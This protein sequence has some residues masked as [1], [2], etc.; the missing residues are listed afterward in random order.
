[1]IIGIKSGIYVSNYIRDI[2]KEIKKIDI[3]EHKEDNIST[4]VKQ[5]NIPF[6]LLCVCALI[7]N[8]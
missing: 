1:M 6:V 7:N 3:E 4:V 8:F 5:L 2:H